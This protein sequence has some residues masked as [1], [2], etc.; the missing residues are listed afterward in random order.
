[1]EFSFVFAQ[2]HCLSP[3]L[4]QIF[5]ILHTNM[6]R[7][8]PTGEAYDQDFA[9]W[10]QYIVPAMERE[11]RQLVLMLCNGELAG[12]FQYD[13][14]C[15][16]W[17]MEEIQIKPEYQGAGLFQAMY[18]WLK[19]RLPAGVIYAEA[20]SHKDNLKSQGILEHLG[21][22]KVGENKSGT[23]FH[24]RGLCCKLWEKLC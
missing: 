19:K 9:L 18:Q 22:E 5:H 17:I 21:L 6:S 7:I 15:E 23:S 11:Q 3:I 10:R 20:Y 16:L 12:Y 8:A 13:I 1:M 4:P 14:Q 2:K 24:Y